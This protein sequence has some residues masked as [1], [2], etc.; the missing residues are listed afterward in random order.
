MAKFI[1]K[2]FAVTETNPDNIEGSAEDA[3]PK[4]AQLSS[5][6]NQ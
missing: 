2:Q 4:M 1:I 6:I 3:T 5:S